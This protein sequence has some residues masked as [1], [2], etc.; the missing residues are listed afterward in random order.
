MKRHVW[1]I[2]IFLILSI[3]GCWM[4]PNRNIVRVSG[5]VHHDDLEGGF[6]A[7]RGDD[8]TTY[9]PMNGL[10]PEFQKG[11]L[12]VRFEGKIRPDAVGTHMVGPI[13][14]ITSIRRL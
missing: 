13:V 5:T 14:E 3:S 11:G 2:A 10:A 9:D 12:R 7:I 6:W 8:G 1:L 4:A